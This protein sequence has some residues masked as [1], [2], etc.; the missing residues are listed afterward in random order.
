MVANSYT[1]YDEKGNY[2]VI[3]QDLIQDATFVVHVE[4]TR[5]SLMKLWK[6]HKDLFVGRIFFCIK[7]V[8]LFENH[9][10]EVEDGLFEY[11][12]RLSN[13]L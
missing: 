7:D 1:V 3:T 12:G 13:R 10:V 4:G 8:N 2:F 9:S 6:E 5:K 11:V